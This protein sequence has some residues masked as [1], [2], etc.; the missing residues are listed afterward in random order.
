MSQY[1]GVRTRINPRIDTNLVKIMKRHCKCEKISEQDFI[2]EAIAHSL[3]VPL[4]LNH[5]LDETY[6]AEYQI[7]EI[8]NCIDKLEKQKKELQKKVVK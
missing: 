8:D 5:M 4:N 3:N 1:D 7:R 2:A 6:Y